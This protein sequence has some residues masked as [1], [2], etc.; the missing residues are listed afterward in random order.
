MVPEME[1]V[2]AAVA[3]EVKLAPVML[4]VVIGFGERSWAEG[5]AGVARRYGVAALGKAREGVGTRGVRGDVVA[6][7]VPVR[8]TVA[9]LPPVPLMVPEMENVCAAVAVEVKLAPV[10]FAVV[11]VSASEVGL[12]VKP[13]WLGVTV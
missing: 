9:P 3:V 1:N 12:K 7:D 5:E 10:M 6:E 4:A 13:V 11:T 8:V 2:C